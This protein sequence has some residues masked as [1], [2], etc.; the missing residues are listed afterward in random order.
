MTG[1][2]QD[3]VALVT[4]GSSGIGRAAAVA[5]AREGARVVLVANSDVTGGRETELAIRQAGG[6]ATFVRADVS[7]ASEVEAL[8]NK[9]VELYGGL[10]C[11]LNNAGVDGS[12]ATAVDC[13]EAGW[14]RTIGV[15]LKGVWLCLKYEIQ[16]MRAHGGGAIVNISSVMG[17]NVTGAMSDYIASKHG[18]VGLT[19]ATALD[20]ACEGVRVNVVCPGIID[21]RMTRQTLML[22]PDFET[23]LPQV[24]PMGR[25]GQPEEVAAAVLW[26]CSEAASFVTG[27]AL[28]VDGGGALV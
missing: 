4:G 26:L 27:V 28:P 23:I 6:E 13:T 18:M 10:H 24:T 3:K 12:H 20:Y 19:K 9:T 2:L 7:Q 11:A 25:L 1:Q 8:V 5:F 15:N 14:D 21:T 17:L 22:A 16:W